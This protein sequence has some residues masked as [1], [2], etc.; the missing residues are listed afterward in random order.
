[1]SPVAALSE[2][3]SAI[4]LAFIR[5]APL[6]LVPV[7]SP[8]ARLP[9][10]VRIFI[11]GVVAVIAVQLHYVDGAVVANDLAAIISHAPLELAL[12]IAMALGYQATVAA[13]MTMG[14]VMDLQMGFGAAGVLNPSTSSSESLIGTIL[15]WLMMFI[16]VEVGLHYDIVAALLMSFDVFPVGS[17][18]PAASPEIF[19]LLFGEQFTLALL[20]AMPVIALLMVFDVL[21]GIAAKGMPQMNVYFITLPLKIFIGIVALWATTQTIGNGIVALIENMRVF[22]ISVLMV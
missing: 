6:L 12:G 22:W 2:Q 18:L 11:T 9:S 17:A 19:L 16:A 14:R 4:A 7:V 20:L 15:M 3:L 5:L 21:I 8:A 1:M 13:L 10:T